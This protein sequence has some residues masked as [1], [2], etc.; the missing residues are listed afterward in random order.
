[1]SKCCSNKCKKLSMLLLIASSLGIIAISA[2]LY[3]TGFI[4]LHIKEFKGVASVSK[5][6]MDYSAFSIYLSYS[7]YA[8]VAVGLF[9]LL[10]AKLKKPVVA[11]LFVFIAIAGSGACLY[12]ANLA[13]TWK[14]SNYD[15][16][17]TFSDDGNEIVK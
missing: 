4:R 10:A 11:T 15:E 1:M 5:W 2:I 16:I 7:S 3:L 9:G 8:G 6:R 14:V 17:C 12:T 13:M